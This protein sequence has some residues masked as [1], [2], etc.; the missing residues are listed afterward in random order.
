MLAR[1]IRSYHRP[2]RLEDAFDLAARGVVP[3]AGGTRLLAEDR[4]LA[5]LLDLSGIGIDGITVDDGDLVLGAMVSLQDAID[6]R[7]AYELTAGLLP[8]ACRASSPSRMLRNMAT[9]GGESVV[10]AWDSEVAAALLA[11]NAVYTV[12][13]HDETVEV[14]AIRFLRRAAEDLAGGGLVR[15][16]LIP[17]APGGA[18][19]ERAALPASGPS[20]VSVAL[21]LSLSGDTC[22]R[23]RIAVTG[24]DGPPS[25]VTEAEHEI[26]G[27][28]AEPHAVEAMVRQVRERPR[29]RDDALASAD[30]RREVAG[31]LAAR[32]LRQALTR[33]GSPGDLEIPRLRTSPSPR[34]TLAIPYFTSGKID[35]TLNG[36]ARRLEAEAR[37]TLLELV[38][39]ERLFGA[40]NGCETGD[41]G[42]CTVLLDGR[43]VIGCLTLALRAH[44]RNVA[45]VEGMGQPDKPHPVQAA[46]IDSGAV[47]CGFC[48]PAMEL[49]AKALL[50]AVPRPTEDEARDA[51][52]GCRCRCGGH[53][54]PVRAV[55]EASAGSLPR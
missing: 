40:K 32:A 4:E 27:S 38:R 16:V 1:G 24:L 20:L 13:R 30:Y 54:R 47:Q 37:T 50:D 34:A 28:E 55:L 48:T 35:V 41:C 6:S 2:T 29:Y 11:L 23:A 49:C 15:S 14:P 51:L 18:A 53:A 44:G 43:P 45:T 22:A 52:A 5:N 31:T 10:A 21:T 33:A 19:L 7:A 17:G 42:T 9:L 3:M 46:F 25:R 36:H 8:A 12:S 39:R 26:E